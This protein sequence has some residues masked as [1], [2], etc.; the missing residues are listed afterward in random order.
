VHVRLQCVVGSKM[1][2]SLPSEGKEAKR[3]SLTQISQQTGARRAASVRQREWHGAGSS[4]LFSRGV[5]RRS[6]PPA[7]LT[8]LIDCNGGRLTRVY[9]FGN[10]P[11]LTPVIGQGTQTVSSQRRQ[12]VYTCSGS[13]FIPMSNF[14]SN[15]TSSSRSQRESRLIAC[16]RAVLRLA[17]S[18]IR[19]F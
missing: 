4:L 9:I 15:R 10:H 18:L 8:R 7:P 1:V 12:I 3:E 16:S 2:D 13:F 14:S 6:C 19:R 5:S 17:S 11:S